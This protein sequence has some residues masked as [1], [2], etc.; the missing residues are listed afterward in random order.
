[1]TSSFCI[2]QVTL[3][4]TELYCDSE[5]VKNILDFLQVLNHLSFQQKRV[6]FLFC[7]DYDI[8]DP[9]LWEVN[10]ACLS[11]TLLSKFQEFNC[12]V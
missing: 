2:I 1:M 10:L 11:D 4:P 9:H 8:M 7:S 5:F 6:M 12:P 3:N